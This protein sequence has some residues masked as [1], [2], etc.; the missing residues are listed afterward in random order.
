MLTAGSVLYHHGSHWNGG[1]KYNVVSHIGKGAFADV[2][3]FATKREGNVFAVKQLEKARFMKNGNL[4]QKF[5]SE[6]RIMEMI[7]H[8]SPNPWAPVAGAYAL[9]ITSPT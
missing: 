3:K 9:T 5:L 2:F 1:E 4:D 8:V 6:L 7:D